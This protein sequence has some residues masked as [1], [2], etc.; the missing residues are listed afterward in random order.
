M[1]A[2]R[3]VAPQGRC[4][5]ERLTRVHP[6]PS[7]AREGGCGLG[8]TRPR[9]PEVRG[10]RDEWGQ[11]RRA[12]LDSL[13]PTA[14]SRDTMSVDERRREAAGKR[15]SELSRRER[16]RVPSRARLT[17]AHGQGG[18]RAA[19]RS[20]RAHARACRTSRTSE[21]DVQ[22]PTGTARGRPPA[23]APHETLTDPSCEA[24]APARG[25]GQLIVASPRCL[26]DLEGAREGRGGGPRGGGGEDEDAPAVPPLRSPPELHR[27][28]LAPS[29]TSMKRMGR[30][31][32]RRRCRERSVDQGR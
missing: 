30:S 26:E 15:E 32:S 18:Q 6:L 31:G 22:G 16:K 28:R 20:A 1:V 10:R 2:G 24:V 9:R 29:W 8:R 4:P 13:G 3:T 25:S 5:C 12:F 21:R 11:Q 7:G 27:A 23:P 14:F 19:H 17:C